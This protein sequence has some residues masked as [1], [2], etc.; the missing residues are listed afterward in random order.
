LFFEILSEIL[1]DTVKVT[2]DVDEL[3]LKWKV[4]IPFSTTG[5]ISSAEAL[6]GVVEFWILICW[7]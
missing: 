1:K 5:F 3:K 6:I 7:K 2:F 4:P